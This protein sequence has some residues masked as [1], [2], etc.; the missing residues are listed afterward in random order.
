MDITLNE[1]GRYKFT[2]GICNIKIHLGRLTF[3][4]DT[5]DDGSLIHVEL[6]GANDYHFK[7]RYFTSDTQIMPAIGICQGI[8][9]SSDEDTTTLLLRASGGT[10]RKH[11]GIS[12]HSWDQLIKIPG[13]LY[14]E[15]FTIH[16]NTVNN[17]TY[18]FHIFGNIRLFFKNYNMAALDGGAYGNTHV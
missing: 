10:L 12:I 16:A 8:F 2:N 18:D 15:P 6:D 3:D 5:P 7:N 9:D 1:S 17:G 13:V 14:F 11:T 4:E